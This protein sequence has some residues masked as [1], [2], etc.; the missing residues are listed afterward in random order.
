VLAVRGALVRNHICQWSVAKNGLNLYGDNLGWS[1]LPIFSIML[2]FMLFE[3]Y[4]M[5][6]FLPVEKC[7]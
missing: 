1:L 3:K 5:Q 2:V 7:G 6:I 4:F